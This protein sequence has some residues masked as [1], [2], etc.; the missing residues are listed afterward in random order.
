MRAFASGTI[1]SQARRDGKHPADGL[2]HFGAS[3]SRKP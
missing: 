3:Q 1:K 2:P